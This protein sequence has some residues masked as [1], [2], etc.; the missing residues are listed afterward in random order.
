M[1]DTKPRAF[2]PLPVIS[3]EVANKRFW[4][5][6]AKTDGCWLWKGY[7]SQ[8]GYGYFYCE[9]KGH[10]AHRISYAMAKGSIPE[11]L[12]VDH[13]CRNTACVNPDHLE[14]VSSREN[15][16]RGVVSE[17][18]KRRFAAQTHCK[19][20]HEYTPE[21]TGKHPQGGRVC[22]ACARKNNKEY[23]R[24]LREEGPTG[25]TFAEVVER[26]KHADAKARRDGK[27]YALVYA[28]DLRALVQRVEEMGQ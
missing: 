16:R 1:D 6:V 5:K 7:V 21:N 18:N 15:T 28:D 23:A 24:R 26:A 10:Q 22:K 12:V 27:L 8:A 9:R 4:P 11:G 19:R 17:V 2:L 13:L 14:A 3:A 25:A 20:G